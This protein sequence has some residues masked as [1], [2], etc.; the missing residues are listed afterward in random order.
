MRSF[1]GID[2]EY[3]KPESPDLVIKTVDRSV[4]EC[5]QQVVEMLMEHGILPRS[6]SESVLELF[7]PENQLSSVK[8]EAE[9][10]PKLQISTLDLQWLQILS[11]GWATPLTGFMR[12]KQYLQVMHF[13][14]LMEGGLFNQ[15]IPIVLPVTTED[16]ERLKSNNGIAL[17]HDGT[18]YA[19]LRD[20]EF[21]EHRKE[22]R[23]CRQFGICNLGHPYQKMIW[24]SGDWLVGGDLQVLKRICWNDGMDHYRLTPNE[25]KAKFREIGADAIFVFQLRNPIHNG[26]ALLMQDTQKQ[27]VERGYRKPVL[28]LH[29]LGGWTKEDD[30]PLDVR[31]EQHKAVLEDG[32]LDPNT[33]IVAIFP[34]PMMYAGPKEVQWHAKA[35]M[36]TGAHFYIVGR[37]PAGMPHPDSP[38][39]DLYDPTHG[40]K[41]LTMAPGLTQLEIIPF[42]VAAYD[43]KNQCMAFFNPKRKEDFDFISGTSMRGLARSGQDPPDGFMGPKAWQV[44]A[45]YYKSLPT[46]SQ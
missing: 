41:V 8:E 27:L 5:V 43:R 37:D 9:L 45:S 36:S 44:L 10:L 13:G 39:Q 7:V 11:E 24:D 19:I 31:M 46:S 15:S 18:I 16:K 20:P 29:P 33:T 2:A 14:C 3:E 42:R 23:C 22:E 26:H 1:T 6:F 40:A 34:S 38:K 17:V 4:D 32:I 21:Y 12:E 30:V 28:L 25:L 35:R